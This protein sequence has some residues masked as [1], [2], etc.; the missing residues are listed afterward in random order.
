MFISGQ[1]Q[2]FSPDLATNS[3][4]NPRYFDAFGTPLILWGDWESKM[5]NRSILKKKPLKNI[6]ILSRGLLIKSV[7]RDLNS[8]SR[9]TRD[10][11]SPDFAHLPSY[12]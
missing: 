4:P 10:L 1:I 9:M 3:V 8:H 11:Q 12:G 6:L 5:N 2:T 7:R